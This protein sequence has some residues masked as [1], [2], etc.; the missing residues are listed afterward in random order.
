MRSSPLVSALLMLCIGMFQVQGQERPANVGIT[1]QELMGSAAFR[2]AGL[3]KLSP[4]QLSALNRW[5]AEYTI[6]VMRIGAGYVTSEAV[7]EDKPSGEVIE[8]HI[9]GSFH[10]WSGETVFK[11]ENGQ[12]WQQ[13]EYDYE[14][15]YAYRPEVLIYPSGGKF[16]MKVEG[17]D[18]TLHVRKLAGV[19]ESQIS[20]T[21]EGWDG[22]TVFKLTNGQ[23]WQQASLSIVVHVAVNPR[24]IIFSSGGGHKMQ[25]EGVSQTIAVSRLR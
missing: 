19:I 5:L 23:V 13:A 22:D 15:H 25:V 7:A 12:Y 9:A 20:G 8:S 3:E 4:E 11:L 6:R 16:A 17:M 21:F 2:E 24:V 18:E 1:I 14:Y 10:G